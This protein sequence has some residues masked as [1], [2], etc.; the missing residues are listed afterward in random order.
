MNSRTRNSLSRSTARLSARSFKH[1]LLVA[2]AV[3]GVTK[4]SAA[5]Q[6]LETFLE[7]ARSYSIG[8][9]ES[10]ATR[11]QREAEADVALGRLVPSFSARGVYTHNQYEAAAQLPMMEERLVITPQNQLDAFL[12]LDVPLIDL[13]N[14]YRYKSSSAVA[15]AAAEQEAASAIDVDRA[16]TRAYYLHAGAAA[17]ARS[18][19]ESVTAAE[20]NLLYVEARK[21]AGAATDLDQQRAIANVERARQDV[22]DADLAMALAARTL[23]TLSGLSPT[24]AEAPPPD[25]LH[26]EPALATWLARVGQTP[27]ERATRALS[28]A[29]SYGEKASRAAL[30]P[31]LS[32]TAQERFTNATGF[33]GRSAAYTL[34]LTLAWRLDYSALA[35]TRAQAAAVGVQDVRNEGV[36]RAVA[37]AIFEAYRRVEAGIA[38]SRAARAQSTAAARAAALAQ[39]RY[40]AGMATQL[41]VTQAQR[42]D[43]LADAARIQADADLA[44]ARAALRLAVGLSP[45]QRSP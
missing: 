22:A 30:L 32:G 26:P 17:I 27:Q 10:A 44:Y 24:P 4:T 36:R 41:D 14:Y 12:Q 7:K 28:D 40:G 38:K 25:D 9:R 11:V 23:E 18:A 21:S 1:A 31:T 8:T 42:D 2:L 29:V 3:A 20:A 5:T 33:S 39:D 35:N 45:G 43:F 16:V 37:D 34:S 13:A 6:P 19:R 15:R